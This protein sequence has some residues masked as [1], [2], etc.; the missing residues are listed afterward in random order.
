M[1]STVLIIFGK[2]L[3]T[4]ALL[5]AILYGFLHLRAKG[6]LLDKMNDTLSIIIL[7]LAFGLTIYF[8]WLRGATF[9]LVF[10]DVAF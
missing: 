6:N 8:M 3:L 1:I 2:I 7:Y 5:F 4:G 9:T 10:L